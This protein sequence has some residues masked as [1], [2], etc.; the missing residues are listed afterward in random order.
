MSL[1]DRVLE[2]YREPAP[3]SA[4]PYGWSYRHVQRLGPG[5]SVSLLA[6]PGA[7]VSVTDLLP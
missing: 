4:T 5:A 2:V 1:V 6:A 7:S 3:S